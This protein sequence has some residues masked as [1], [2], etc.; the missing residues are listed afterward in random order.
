MGRR[1]TMAGAIRWEEVPWEKVNEKVSRKVIMGD[2]MM[3]IMYR[4]AAGT[5][6]PEESHLAEQ[7]GYLLKGRLEFY[8]KGEKNVIL[9]GDSFFV[10]SNVPHFGHIAEELTSIEIF[11]PPRKE[12]MGEGMGFAPYAAQKKT[13][14]P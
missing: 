9:P 7:W 10:E 2:R 14:V 1:K 13:S 11:S 3:I 6:W 12:L 4:I 5:V 8:V